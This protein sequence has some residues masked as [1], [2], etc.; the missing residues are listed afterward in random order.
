[1]IVGNQGEQ[2][3]TEAAKICNKPQNSNY[4]PNGLTPSSST[5]P[6]WRST[7]AVLFIIFLARRLCHNWHVGVR[8][9]AAS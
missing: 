8:L 7:G 3:K 2:H 6:E 5:L 9:Q 1:M 4:E